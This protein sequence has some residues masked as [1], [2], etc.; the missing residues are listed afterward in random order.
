MEQGTRAWQWWAVQ[1][2]GGVAGLGQGWEAALGIGQG[3][4]QQRAVGVG[5]LQAIREEAVVDRCLQAEALKGS[6]EKAAP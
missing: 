2:H 3:R 1:H 6:L 4:S 5:R